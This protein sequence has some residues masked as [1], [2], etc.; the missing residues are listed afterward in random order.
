MS[1][2][3]IPRGTLTC[4]L[5]ALTLLALGGFATFI[6]EDVV[7]RTLAVAAVLWL[8][9]LPYYF[10]IRMESVGNANLSTAWLAVCIW[11]P[12]A[13]SDHW[14]NCRFDGLALWLAV[15]TASTWRLAVAVLHARESRSSAADRRQPHTPSTECGAES[16]SAETPVLPAMSEPRGASA[17]TC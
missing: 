8:G 15:G 10:G 13:A 2:Q 17:R 16:D 11:A 9:F 12:T 1:S 7:P 14:A 4:L 3:A 5:F 6:P